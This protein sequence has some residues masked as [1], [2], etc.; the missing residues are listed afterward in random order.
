[1]FVKIIYYA[2]KCPKCLSVQGGYTWTSSIIRAV[3][4]CKKC[5]KST[6]IFDK[7]ERCFRVRILKQSENPHYISEFIQL[8]KEEKHNL[9]VMKNEI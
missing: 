8:Y 2:A 1:V 9:E 7:K 4:R 6:K 5:N 3:F